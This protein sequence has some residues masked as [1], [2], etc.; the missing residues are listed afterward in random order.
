MNKIE[1]SPDEVQLILKALNYYGDESLPDDDYRLWP[2][3]AAL[4]DRLAIE[5]T[6]QMAS[7]FAYSYEFVPHVAYTLTFGG[8]DG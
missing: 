4:H 7:G 2:A 3:A 5:F 6:H 1:L 8:K